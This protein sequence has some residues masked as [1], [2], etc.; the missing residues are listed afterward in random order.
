MKTIKI[1]DM[2]YKGQQWVSVGRLSPDTKPL[3]IIIN[4]RGAGVFCRDFTT[5]L[6]RGAGLLGGL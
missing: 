1:W 5:N 6:A 2:A 4:P 3:L